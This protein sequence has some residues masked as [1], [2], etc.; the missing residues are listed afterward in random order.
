MSQMKDLPPGSRIEVEVYL[1]IPGDRYPT[2]GS[3][4]LTTGP[5][6]TI[7]FLAAGDP[8]QRGAYE[9]LEKIWPQ[10]IDK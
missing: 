10:A 3:T 4:I 5:T 6:E 9:V 8:V 7:S 1:I 2:Q